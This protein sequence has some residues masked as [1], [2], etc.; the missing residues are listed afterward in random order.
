MEAETTEGDNHHHLTNTTT[1]HS[2]DCTHTPAHTHTHAHA[3]TRTHT[4]MQWTHPLKSRC[5]NAGSSHNEKGRTVRL[6]LDRSR[7]VSA[8]SAGP[9][10]DSLHNSEIPM[11]VC[12]G[13]GK[14][15][16]H[17][18]NARGRCTLACTSFAGVLCQQ[19]CDPS[20]PL[21]PTHQAQCS[22]RTH[23][24]TACRGVREEEEERERE[25]GGGVAT[26]HRATLQMHVPSKLL[27][28]ISEQTNS[29][30]S[31]VAARSMDRWRRG[32]D[33]GGGGGGGGASSVR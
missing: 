20:D 16:V 10:C 2:N 28:H 25:R 26:Y 11:D 18:Q 19:A 17:L 27:H 4:H 33:E 1:T 9:V 29:S 8:V 24:A 6:L 13:N 22:I 3:R 21:L 12:G 32:L 7:W 30:P 31:A 14:R 5:S 23:H 15:R